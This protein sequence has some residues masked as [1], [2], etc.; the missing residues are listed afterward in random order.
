MTITELTNLID[1]FHDAMAKIN[2]EPC[3]SGDIEV[4]KIDNDTLYL[5]DDNDTSGYSTVS[6]SN[7]EL[8][9]NGD[10]RW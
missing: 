5:R 8:A 7:G 2:G 9:L 1:R 3:F 6:F 4:I 10:T